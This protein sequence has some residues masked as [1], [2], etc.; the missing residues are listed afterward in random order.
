LISLAVSFV[1]RK[2]YLQPQE[3]L[4]A[5]VGG[6]RIVSMV[7]VAKSI[8]FFSNRGGCNDDPID[9]PLM[10]RSDDLEFTIR[11]VA[12]VRKQPAPASYDRLPPGI[13]GDTEALRGCACAEGSGFRRRSR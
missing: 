10:Q 4:I 13:T 2:H 6:S 3:F 9:A 5:K 1:S 12:G 11:I 8:L 7:S